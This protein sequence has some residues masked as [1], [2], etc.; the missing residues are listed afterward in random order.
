[1]RYRVKAMKSGQG[2]VSLELDA[3]DLAEARTQAVGR[4]YTVLSVQGG[5]RMRLPSLA[6]K[7]RFPLLLFTQE[8]LA[9]LQSGI[10]LVEALETLEEKESKAETRSAL[11]RLLSALYEGKPF[12][13]A[14]QLEPAAFPELY[15][16]TVR[17]SERTGGLPEALTRYVA[18]QS[19]LDV[20]RKKLVSASIYPLILMGVGG[21]V[22]LFLLGYVVPRFSH[23]Y[24]EMGDDIPFMSRLLMEWGQ[25]IKSNGVLVGLAFL[26]GGAGLV[27]WLFQPGSRARILR[28]FRRIPSMGE[29]L[30]V[31]QL[32]RFYRTLGMLLAGG[33]AIVPA[34]QMVSG[35][36]D[37]ELRVRLERASRLIREGQPISVSMESTGLVTPVSLRLLRVGERSG[38]MGEMMER[39]AAFHDEEMARWVE[40]FTKIFEPLLMAFIGVVIGGIV[41]LMY[42][43][44]FEL[45]GSIQ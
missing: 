43:P 41:V 10:S 15:V 33:I 22:A 2:V 29:R 35:L 4:G 26:A 24:E 34:M 39:I 20:V 36:L 42:L 21:L 31:Y 1:M 11:K 32:A 45:A 40:W 3:R 19:Q 17:A 13:S 12:S 37:A 44:I 8:L 23:V 6:R 38:Q 28:A 16:A 14:L 27:W 25:L 30:R 5:A 9:L 18:Y 7:A